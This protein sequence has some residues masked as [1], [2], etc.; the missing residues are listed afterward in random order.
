MQVTVVDT[1]DG[2]SH[3]GDGDGTSSS[4]SSSNRLGVSMR[5]PKEAGALKVQFL[6]EVG[7]AEVQPV[8]GRMEVGEERDEEQLQTVG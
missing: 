5:N 6:E 2:I 1:V 4:S 3:Q 8:P 7:A